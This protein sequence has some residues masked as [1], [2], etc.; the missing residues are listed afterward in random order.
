MT[1]ARHTLVAV[2]LALPLA[3]AACGGG[4]GKGDDGPA[5]GL[6]RSNPEAVSRAYLATY[7][8]CGDQGAG[9][10]WDLEQHSGGADTTSKAEELAIEREDGCRP[11]KVPPVQ[12]AR[13]QS[14]GDFT[15]VLVTNPDFCGDDEGQIVLVRTSEGWLVDTGRTQLNSEDGSSAACVETGSSAGNS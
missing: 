9:L 14:S 4:D 7:Y 13:G 15:A 3:V 10:R 11:T 1:R 5:G 12:T 2:A 6:D 8:D